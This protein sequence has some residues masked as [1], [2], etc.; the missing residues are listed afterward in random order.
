MNIT[1][2]QEIFYAS[3]HFLPVLAFEDLHLDVTY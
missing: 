3:S 2:I 1:Y